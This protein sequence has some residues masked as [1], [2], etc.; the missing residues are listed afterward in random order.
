MPTTLAGEANRLHYA[1][2]QASRLEA[3]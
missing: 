3:K 1:I 2:E